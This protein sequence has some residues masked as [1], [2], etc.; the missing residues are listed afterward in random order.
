MQLPCGERRTLENLLKRIRLT[1]GAK[2]LR[3]K[4]CDPDTDPDNRPQGQVTGRPRIRLCGTDT[5][6]TTETNICLLRL[7]NVMAW[8]RVTVGLYTQ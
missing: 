6:I 8:G 1:A 4:G 3:N 5:N 2:Q 7:S